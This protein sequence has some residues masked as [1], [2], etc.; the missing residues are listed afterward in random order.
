MLVVADSSALIALSI[1]QSLDL[2]VAIYGNIIVPQAVYDE[3]VQPDRS[4]ASAL[5][6][7][8]EDRILTANLER[9]VFNAGGLGQGEL[10]A[11]ALYREHSADFL[12]IDD[13]RARTIAEHNHINC[14]GSLGVLLSAKKQGIIANVKPAIEKLRAS[15]LYYADEL[16]NKVL[17]LANEI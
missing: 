17:E 4:Q 9:F 14:I 8:L 16:L 11:M 5:A 6:I 2:L 15:S 12:L 1:S 3:V 7:F 10:E 13:R